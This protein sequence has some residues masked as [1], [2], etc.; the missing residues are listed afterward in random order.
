MKIQARRSVLTSPEIDAVMIYSAG[1]EVKT[2]ITGNEEMSNDK[3][4]MSNAKFLRDGQLLI[5]R[6]GKTYNAQGARVE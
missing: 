5:L 6:D 3:C 1:W 2:M 4:Q